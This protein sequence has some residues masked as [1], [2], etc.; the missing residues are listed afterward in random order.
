[1][2]ERIINQLIKTLFESQQLVLKDGVNIKELTSELLVSLEKNRTQGEGF[3]N[4][5]TETIIISPKVEELY[6]SDDEIRTLFHNI[7]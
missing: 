3:I 4:W 7:N 1:M 5:F 2:V 6:A